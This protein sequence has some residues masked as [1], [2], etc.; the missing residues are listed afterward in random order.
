MLLAALLNWRISADG[1]HLDWM[2]VGSVSVE[3]VSLFLLAG[4]ARAGHRTR[5][6]DMRRGAGGSLDAMRDSRTRVVKAPGTT[7]YGW[8]AGGVGDHGVRGF[9]GYRAVVDY[10]GRQIYGRGTAHAGY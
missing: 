9:A 4:L 1:G 3:V 6:A 5:T 7:G 2:V 10:D 8:D